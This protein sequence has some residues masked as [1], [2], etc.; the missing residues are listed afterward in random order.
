MHSISFM[1]YLQYA[2]CCATYSKDRKGPL[3]P[4]EQRYTFLKQKS[5]YIQMSQI[6]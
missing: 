4:T 1:E 5:K 3:D 2:Q 6:V